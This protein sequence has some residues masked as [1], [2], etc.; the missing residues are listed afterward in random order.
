MRHDG[1]ILDSQYT[2]G[3]TA[4]NNIQV[5]QAGCYFDIGIVS[6]GQALVVE[7]LSTLTLIFVAFGIALDPRRSSNPEIGPALIGYTTG[8]LIFTTG[9]LMDGYYGSC[10]PSPIS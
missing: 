5:P 9:M 2:L 8:I 1:G 3:I 4:V 7:I 10:E 6:Y